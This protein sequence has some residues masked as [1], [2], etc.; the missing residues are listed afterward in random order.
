MANFEHNDTLD[1]PEIDIQHNYLYSLFDRLEAITAMSDTTTVK[2]L[3]EE[4][5]RY[6]MYH[7]ANEQ[8]LMRM[9]NF[10]GFAIHQG[11]HEQAESKF[12]QFLDDFEK[13]NLNPVA[14]RIF[15]T[16]WLTEH[17]RLSDSE[18]VKWIKKQRSLL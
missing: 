18:Y 7:F 3:L 17:S 6:L 11:D 12:V 14:L 4:I 2:K 10:P 8:H 13:N 5:E 9:Y 1:F 16:G 15:L